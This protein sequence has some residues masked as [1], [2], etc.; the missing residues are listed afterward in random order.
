[1]TTYA[2]VNALLIMK[3]YKSLNREEIYKFFYSMKRPDGSFH[4]HLNGYFYVFLMISEFD[5][6]SCYCV[7]S[8]CKLLNMLTPEIAEH[9]GEY[10]LRSFCFLF[11]ISSCQTYEG[12][13]ASNPGSEAHGGYTFC[14][15]AAL[16]L[17]NQL[18][19]CNRSALEVLSVW[20]SE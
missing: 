20:N 17:L 3:S 13:F 18:H 9:V 8:I 12:G 2:G 14:S 19:K 5:C 11:F 10:I 1:M 16:T 6:R 7:L 15:V 4:V